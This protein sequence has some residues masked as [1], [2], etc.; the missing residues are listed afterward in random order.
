MR[1]LTRSDTPV[2]YCLFDTAIGAV[3]MAWREEGVLRLQLPEASRAATERRLCGRSTGAIEAEPPREI[4]QAMADVRRYLVGERIDFCA[5]AVDLAGVSAFHCRIYEVARRIRWGETTTYGA[6]AG[7]A[8]CPDAAR[9]VG[10]AMGRNPVPI[11]IPCHRVLASGGKAGGFSA[12]GGAATKERLLA[13]EGVSLGGGVPLLP[14]LL[15][16]H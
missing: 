16:A 7:Q 9:A 2:R 11:I 13:L 15:P 14:G 1:M 5:T 6:L 10:Q 12:F 3:G 8:G 4:E